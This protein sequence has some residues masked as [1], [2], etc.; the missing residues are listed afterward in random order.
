MTVQSVRAFL[1]REMSRENKAGALLMMLT[2]PCHAVMLLFLL[3]GTAIGSVL[4]VFRAWIYLGFTVLFLV[5]LYLMV[6][7]SSCAVPPEQSPR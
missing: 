5:G 3:G 1:L 7:P 4:A 6:R 2:C